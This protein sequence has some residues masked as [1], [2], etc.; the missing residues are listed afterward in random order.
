MLFIKIVLTIFF[1]LILKKV[2]SKSLLKID[3]RMNE[4]L[5]LKSIQSLF[6]LLDWLQLSIFFGLFIILGLKLC[7][8]LRNFSKD[9]SQDLKNL[10]CSVRIIWNVTR[11][12]NINRRLKFLVRKTIKFLG[13]SRFERNISRTSFHKCPVDKMRWHL[14][15]ASRSLEH[16]LLRTS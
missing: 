3:L 16:P 6:R 13:Y 5:N 12:I 7:Y 1:S 4:Y 15:V 10:F 14:S 2:E 8:I 11:C 9:A